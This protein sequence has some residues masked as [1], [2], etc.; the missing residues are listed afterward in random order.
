MIP[1]GVFALRQNTIKLVL[2]QNLPF[3]GKLV[4]VHSDTIPG[5]MDRVQCNVYHTLAAIS[6]FVGAVVMYLG[7][8]TSFLPSSGRAEANQVWMWFFSMWVLAFVIVFLTR[9]LMVRARRG[10]RLRNR[11]AVRW[12]DVI[13]TAQAV[14]CLAYLLWGV[15]ARLQGR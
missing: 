6:F 15:S 7:V 8:G 5:I 13:V 14:I 2:S 10:I 11:R 9:L 3:V 12:T 4:T 1:R